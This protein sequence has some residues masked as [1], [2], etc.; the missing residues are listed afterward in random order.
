MITMHQLPGSHPHWFI[1]ALV[2]SLLLV[3]FSSFFIVKAFKLYKKEHFDATHDFLTG[4]RNLRGLTIDVGQALKNQTNF[5]LAVLD[6][7]KFK[8]INDSIGH[9]N[10]DLVLKI[11]VERLKDSIKANLY[12]TDKVSDCS[13]YRKAGDEFFVLI[14]GVINKHEII[15][16][17]KSIIVD[18]RKPIKINKYEFVL[19]LNMGI[20]SYMGYGKRLDAEYF[21]QHA[22]TALYSSKIKGL[23]EYEVYTNEIESIKN[24]LNRETCLLSAL[25]N[26]ELFLVYQPLL[27]KKDYKI[28]DVEALVRWELNGQIFSPNDFIPLAEDTG[29]IIELGKWVIDNSFKQLKDWLDAKVD[30][31]TININIS[32][33]QL[34]YDLFDY[35]KITSDKYNIKPNY[36]NLEITESTIVSC[37]QYMLNLLQEIKDYGFGIS[38][39]DFGC[40]YTSISSL[41]QLPLSQI[42]IDKLFI[43]RLNYVKNNISE[44]RSLKNLLSSLVEMFASLNLSIVIEGI[45]SKDDFDFVNSLNIDFIQGFFVSKPLEPEKLIELISTYDLDNTLGINNKEISGN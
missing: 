21:I 35:L 17:F 16:I 3:V 4:L 7:N 26:N 15:D 39:D 31:D 25:H 43:D 12:L 29:L 23:N 28:K 32:S 1:E 10:G 30:I 19:N 44:Q 24:C 18:L 6:I 41:Y 36:V 13:I 45:E 27:K 8:R 20:E 14:K 22:Y 34:T 37:D 38:M 33:K 11:I 5:S 42:K 40:G 9:N 2:D